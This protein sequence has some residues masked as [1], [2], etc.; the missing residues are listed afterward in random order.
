MTVR[1]FQDSIDEIVAYAKDIQ[2]YDEKSQ[3]DL[4]RARDIME[5]LKCI[6]GMVD[7]KK[8]IVNKFGLTEKGANDEISKMINGIE[9]DFISAKTCLENAVSE[10]DIEEKI[11]ALITA[12]GFLRNFKSWEYGIQYLMTRIRIGGMENDNQ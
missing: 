11:S 8:E 7:A 6:N 12:C 2:E 3:S 4:E 9:K 1:D 5:I 10:K